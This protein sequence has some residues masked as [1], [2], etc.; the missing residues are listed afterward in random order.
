[1]VEELTAQSAKEIIEHSP[2]IISHLI[3][4]HGRSEA[5]KAEVRHFLHLQA[6]SLLLLLVVMW[7]KLI[8]L[9]RLRRRSWAISLGHYGMMPEDVLM[10]E[11]V[12]NPILGPRTHFNFDR[13]LLQFMDNIRKNLRRLNEDELGELHSA[14][15]LLRIPE[16][17]SP[18]SPLH[19]NDLMNSVTTQLVKLPS[20]ILF[21]WHSLPPV[22]S[23]ELKLI[24]STVT[25]ISTHLMAMFSREQIWVEQALNARLLFAS[26]RVDPRYWIQADLMK[27]R[28]EK[29][30][31]A[32]SFGEMIWLIGNSMI[33]SSVLK[34]VLRWLQRIED[35]RHEEKVN[36]VERQQHW[37]NC[38]QE[39]KLEARA[40]Q[41]L[42]KSFEDKLNGR[43][44]PSSD[45]NVPHDF[46][47]LLLTSLVFLLGGL[48]TYSYLNEYFLRAQMLRYLDHENTGK[49]LHRLIDTYR[50]TPVKPRSS[51]E[52]GRVSER[53]RRDTESKPVA[54]LDKLGISPRM[55]VTEPDQVLQMLPKHEQRLLRIFNR[56]RIYQMASI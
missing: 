34:R 28:S 55:T 11:A 56:T 38:W 41:E 33:W 3:T 27:H 42:M 5:P 25:G 19:S 32:Y 47:L 44:Y 23:W 35:G 37:W 52:W 16:L 17:Q 21:K 51:S 24:Y 15:D 8:D 10:N 39:L 45:H 2:L 49:D 30:K 48:C 7:V 50:P 53:W 40:L 18:G 14:V 13:I 29:S 1:M 22:K 46:W 54:F 6:S 12:P 26:V 31:V 4:C 20:V 43:N 36:D 9:E